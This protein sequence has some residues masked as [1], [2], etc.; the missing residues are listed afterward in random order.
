MDAMLA[1]MWLNFAGIIKSN[2]HAVAAKE[3]VKHDLMKEQLKKDYV[4]LIQSCMDISIKLIP[5]FV[6]DDDNNEE[7][8]RHTT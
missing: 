4:L 7:F 3:E 5:E 6:A 8:K 2:A 1:L